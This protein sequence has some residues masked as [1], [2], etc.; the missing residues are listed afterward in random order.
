MEWIILFA[1]SWIALFAFAEPRQLKKNIWC[2][3]LA[4]ALQLV[5]DTHAIS[6][7]LYSINNPM[8]SIMGS[9][10]FFTAGPV[11]TIGTLFAQFYPQKR[12]L[13][14]AN[15]FVF[16]TLFYFQEILLLLS[17]NLTYTNWHFTNSIVIDICVM[18]ILSWFSIVVL[19]KKEENT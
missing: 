14:I 18:V 8:I 12:W 6:Y 2:G 13:R 3:V 17:G 19:D 9:S 10:L 7:G 5:V 11:F 15:I 4:L 1:V 16:S